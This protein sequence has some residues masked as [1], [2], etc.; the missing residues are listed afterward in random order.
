M[1]FKDIFGIFNKREL[2]FKESYKESENVYTFV[3]D[4]DKDAEW[5]AGQ[6]GLFTITHKKIK[7]PIKPFSLVAAPTENTIKITT[8]I[9]DSPSEFKKALMELEKGMKIKMAGPVGGFYVKEP[10]KPTLLIAGGMGITPFRSILK[11]LE[12]EENRV[13]QQINLLYMD[14]DGTYLFKDEFDTIANN[15]PLIKVTYLDSREELHQEIDAFAASNTNNG[16][17]F[18]AGPKSMVTSISD[19]LQHNNISKRNIKKDAFFGY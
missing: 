16:K 6:H 19:H 3:F 8:K 13:E 17:Y 15:N 12:A 4:K 1:S 14:S 18:I 5:K 10:H 11:Q 7:N 9:S 2:I